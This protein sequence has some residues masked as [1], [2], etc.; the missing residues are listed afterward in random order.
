[1]FELHTTRLVVSFTTD[2]E[3]N[4]IPISTAMT[5]SVTST[6]ISVKAD[7]RRSALNEWDE[8]AHD[9]WIV[10][11]PRTSPRKGI[12]NNKF[13]GN[14][15]FAQQVETPIGTNLF[16]WQTVGTRKSIWVKDPPIPPCV[17]VF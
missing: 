10:F 11:T 17:P 4:M 1:M 8:L 12:P 16:A 6:S 13:M 3:G 9:A 14:S 2:N 7:A 5:T 15:P